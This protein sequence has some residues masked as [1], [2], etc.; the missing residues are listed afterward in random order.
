[1][2][3]LTAMIIL[4]G[5]NLAGGAIEEVRAGINGLTG[6]AGEAHGALGGI[7]QGIELG[8]GIAAFQ[9]LSGAIGE[10]ATSGVKF[11]T[12]MTELQNNTTLTTADMKGAQDTILAL[13]N[14]Y[15]V[16]TDSITTGYRHVMD[17]VQNA[18][19]AQEV[20]NVAVEG[21]AA[22]GA[23]AAQV[24]NVL[25][26]VMHEYS[27]D[28]VI[29]ADGTNDLAAEHVNASHTLGIMTAA[30]QDA[31]STLQDWTGSMSAAIGIAAA[32]GQPLEN[33]GALFGAL[34][35]HG[36]PDSA[37]AGLQV[38]DMLI[39]LAHLTPAATAELERLGKTSGVD[40]V[41]DL[42]KMNEGSMTLVDFLGQLREAYLKAGL[43]EAQFREESER[44]IAGQRGGLGLNAALTTGYADMLRIQA[45]LSDQTRVNTVVDDTW[46]RT[47]ETA[48]KQWDILK[49]QVSNFGITL[50]S[51]LLPAI[52]PIVQAMN[53]NL[54]AALAAVGGGF[55]SL[56]NGA[57]TALQ[58]VA[59]KLAETGAAWA[60][61]A[62]QAG[63][64]GV[65]VDKTLTGLSD[66]VQ[67]LQ[68][69]LQGNYAAAWDSA[70]KAMTDFG[71][72]G[73]AVFKILDDNK[74]TIIG[75][76]AA[77]GTFTVLETVVPLVI[78][79][80]TAVAEFAGGI[81]AWIAVMGP[82]EGI[83]GA[84]V[85]VLG[86]PVTLA[87]VGVT[88][89]VGLLTAAWINNWGDI[90]GKTA[91]VAGFIG[92]HMGQIVTA[93]ELPLGPLGWLAIAW[94]NNFGDIQ[95]ST[96][97][98]M[99]GI[100]DTFSELG[101]EMQIVGA[102]AGTLKDDIAAG[103]A[104]IA[105]NIAGAAGRWNITLH[106]TWDTAKTDASSGLDQFR[107][108]INEKTDP[109]NAAIDA[110]AKSWNATLKSWWDRDV[111]EANT[112][113]ALIAKAVDDHFGGAL[114]KL[115]DWNQKLHDSIAAT[116]GGA[117]DAA[118]GAAGGAASAFGTWVSNGAAPGTQTGE[119]NAADLR[120]S[121]FSDPQLS[122]AEALAA[123]GP[124]ALI[125]FMKANGGRVPTLREAV[126]LAQSPAVGGWNTDVGM[127]TGVI[128]EQNLLAAGGLSSTL[129]MSPSPTDIR[130]GA[131]N[132]GEIIDTVHHFF[133]AVG[134]N[135]DTGQFDVGTSGSDLIGAK[136]IPG[137]QGGT[138]LTL[139]QMTGL[140]G[141]VTGILT[142]IKVAA[143]TTAD[144]TVDTAAVVKAGGVASKDDL[145]AYA[146]G[147]AERAGIS[148][149]VFQRQIQQES[150]FNPNVPQH[151]DANNPIIG[152]AQFGAATAKSRGVDPNDP[153][154]A[155][156]AAAQYDAELLK[157]YGNSWEKTLAA[158][159]AGE[160]HVDS[161]APNAQETK[162]Y[163]NI[164]LGGGQQGVD[165]FTSAGGGTNVA[166]QIAPLT[167][168]E[169]GDLAA[170][171]AYLDAGGKAAKVPEI[172]SL[173]KSADT[174]ADWLIT[175][176]AA[177]TKTEGGYDRA[178]GAA[179]AKIDT[180]LSQKLG[181]DL[182]GQTSGDLLAQKNVND[183]IKARKD[184]L[185]QQITDE[186]AA[187]NIKI[188]NDALVTKRA[189]EDQATLS[190]RAREDTTI[191][192]NQKL[193]AQAVVHTRGLQDTETAYQ[194][195]VALQATAHARTL[196]DQKIAADAVLA[197][198]AVAHARQLQDT[199]I[200]YQ[201]GVAKEATLHQQKLQNEQIR[202]AQVLEDAATQHQRA[203][204]DAAQEHTEQLAQQATLHQRQLQDAQLP[205][206]AQL[207]D[208]ATGHSRQL[209]DTEIVY[210][211]GISN[212]KAQHDYQE[213]LNAATTDAQRASL[214]S[215]HATALENQAEA[216]QAAQV[217][218]AH[219]RQLQDAEAQ[220][221]KGL[222]A[223]AL[224]EQ[225]KA[226]DTEAQYQNGLADQAMSY[227]HGLQDTE[228]S[229]QRG[230][231]KTA[232]DQQRA[233]AL[234]ES[235]YQMGL[236]ATELAHQRQLQ[237]TETA[238]QRG[239]AATALAKSR[240]DADTETAYRQN[241]A[242]VEIDH[243]RGLQDTEVGY[244]ID[245]AKKALD[246][247]RVDEDALRADTRTKE[248]ADVAAR[249][250]RDRTAADFV[251]AQ[252]KEQD[253][254]DK[255]LADEAYARQVQQLKDGA[256]LNKKNIADNLIAQK[257]AAVEQYQTDVDA[258]Q[259]A[260]D[261][262]AADTI[263]KA[264]VA[265]E[266]AGGDFA[267]I[268]ATMTAA[269]AAMDTA[270]AT[271]HDNAGASLTDLAAQ[272]N[273][274][275]AA[276]GTVPAAV[277]QTAA[278]IVEGMGDNSKAKASIGVSDR[279]VELFGQRFGKTWEEARPLLGDIEQG[280]YATMGENGLI[281]NHIQVSNDAV[282]AFANQW[283]VSWPEAAAY[284]TTG[285]AKDITNTFGEGGTV[286]T[287]MDQSAQHA[288]DLNIAIQGIKDKTITVTT[289]YVENGA[290]NGTA[291]GNIASTGGLGGIGS[292]SSNNQGGSTAS[293]SGGDF[294]TYA[295]RQA[296]RDSHP[297]AIVDASGAYT[298][299]AL[300]GVT[301]GTIFG[302]D[303]SGHG[304]T[305]GEGNPEAIIPLDTYFLSR[306]SDVQSAPTI[307]YDK[308]AEAVVRAINKNG[309]FAVDIN[310]FQSASLQLKRR[311]GS[312]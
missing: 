288:A 176:Q 89:A 36:F 247:K 284:L 96:A 4:E 156:D 259:K 302:T 289:D 98:A 177:L 268:E 79:A 99:A 55:S 238:Y 252:K 41:D 23:D 170:G 311:G 204:Q 86:G 121:Q 87:I 264:K 16:A 142:D 146:R 42:K 143:A 19:A 61:W 271:A 107:N 298:P 103:I 66:S 277:G 309:A 233:D 255:K 209:Q 251:K 262:D 228:T 70:G 60:P 301:T 110:Y 175:R 149:D 58:G 7:L 147:A 230:L 165:S 95:G 216:A 54:P 241:L 237:D 263:A 144:A 168:A 134:Y 282:I 82:V 261:K 29:A 306:K 71:A 267:P 132:G 76:A 77:F 201:D 20:L 231:A 27:T 273:A 254:L 265:V 21:S 101:T 50:G 53:E 117:A 152:I 290:N 179:T 81:T 153:L 206:T 22:S 130:A 195:G 297:G 78:G 198:A 169:Q 136:N 217:E 244:Q 215:A 203:L 26:G 90:Q 275:L 310:A 229:Y 304:H 18:A 184:A 260:F 197:T 10:V 139:D 72:A 145:I 172:A 281:P 248:D 133:T 8:A 129:N 162:D 114:A 173:Q 80:A 163:L 213:Q 257:V 111:E 13:S 174:G 68:F 190:A 188:A 120:P 286:V 258:H 138:L 67:A 91:A 112:E 308:L 166:P 294:S 157:K 148:P 30:A 214:Q 220:Y 97:T 34:T 256:E 205:V 243:Q 300:G 52:T 194:Q 227:Q 105:A 131:A 196:E 212:A 211:Q 115:N 154:A 118:V 224:A 240:A 223:A 14:T 274:V 307:D 159:N 5:R 222:A 83:L 17:I 305:A 116:L 160:G 57:Q 25:A 221:Q 280:I 219:Q 31:N 239:L 183:D 312:I 283:G 128:G 119:G 122:A 291:G 192:T 279:A 32:G 171:R 266:A 74:G 245:L 178:A 64:A 293:S 269:V 191:Q 48:G 236:K 292:S 186:T 15:G 102:Q 234:T 49:E 1:M 242:K 9:A 35:L 235:N 12:M 296:Y 287:A 43:T 106:T 272:A 92:D 193:A 2:A 100:G 126:T 303:S 113:L 167:P 39:Q 295:G 88:L 51:E 232:L 202:N 46:N 124:A 123:C 73:A 189:D 109:I 285:I 69:L 56:N 33:L 158:Y 3:D 104:P 200:Q 181:D 226:Q 210:Q 44:L 24:A 218:L 11:Q 59:D 108:A 137:S 225:R 250:V 151:G 45:D 65:V 164:I 299:H 125:A 187:N 276:G 38:K 253:D 246:A 270:F 40:V 182:T 207:Q 208:T 185:A 127:V 249:I 199:E 180:G 28:V 150:G 84:T 155:L 37:N 94:Q 140:M 93:L 62:A 75:I 135:P 63:D 278:A 85:A 6:A 47:K 141:Q 161:G